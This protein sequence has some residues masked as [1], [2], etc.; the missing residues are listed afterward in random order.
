MAS[1]LDSPEQSKHFAR[2]ALIGVL[3]LSIRHLM[4]LGLKQKRRNNVPRH[5]IGRLSLTNIRTLFRQF[6]DTPKGVMLAETRKPAVF[7]LWDRTK[8]RGTPIMF[9][10]FRM[11]QGRAGVKGQNQMTY[12]AQNSLWAR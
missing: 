2:M 11:L 5:M 1:W 8:A 3:T 9:G 10:K 12:F 4:F 6:V 7:I